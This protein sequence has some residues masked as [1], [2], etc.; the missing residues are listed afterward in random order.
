SIFRGIKNILLWSYDRGTWQYDAL[1][2]L[3]IS[4]VFLLPSKFFGDRDR[5]AVKAVNLVRASEADYE[6]AS[7][8]LQEFLRKQNRPDLSSNSPE[9]VALYLRDQLK[10]DVAII[11]IEPI[12]NPQ[13]REIYKVRIK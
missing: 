12:K 13:G 7:D 3:I 8:R 1:C 4:A 9:A 5:V 11:N 2:L 6:V 10:R